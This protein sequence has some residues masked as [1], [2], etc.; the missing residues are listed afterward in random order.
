MADLRGA[1][2]DMDGTLLDTEIIARA[3]FLEASARIG[4][5]E[6]DAEPLL[7]S[8]VGTAD[9]EASALLRAGL[10]SGTDIA[11][12]GEDWYANMRRR[13]GEGIEVKATV[14]ETLESR[15]AKGI[16]MAV[17]T[18][19]RAASAERHLDSTGLLT[20]FQTIIGGD[21][22]DTNKPHPGP[23]LAGADMLGLGAG[24]CAAFEDSDIG[25]RSA[26][27]AGCRTVQIPDLRA[28]DAPLPPY[29]Q[30]QAESLAEGA[31]LVGLL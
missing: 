15:Q 25:T 14:I 7:F 27:A 23:Y 16:T 8:L 31:R 9:D 5:P 6:V 20:Y 10:P 4:F 29:G 13:M 19:T 24:E 22:I 2:F 26:T 21:S 12:F 11:A 3:A 28:P 1:L 30:I 17:V 18:S